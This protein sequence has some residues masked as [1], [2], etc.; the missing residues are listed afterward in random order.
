MLR[1][2]PDE[3]G[4]DIDAYG[5]VPLQQ[6]VDAVR[7]RYEEAGEAD[8]LELLDSPDQHR[9]E[10]VEGKIRALYGHSFFVEMDGEPLV[11]PEVLYM[12]TTATDARRFGR[13][14]IVPNDR[15]Y[16]HLSQSREV[17]AERSREPDGPVVIEVM[18]RAAAEAG[19][20]FYARGEV[21]LTRQIP[22]EFVGPVHG[23]RTGASR[24]VVAAGPPRRRAPAPEATTAAAPTE[25]PPTSRPEGPINYGRKLRKAT[26]R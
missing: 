18:A 24:R 19:I 5:F 26:R 23:V 8:V 21:V 12:G 25:E 1:H 11:A 22:V 17:A 10:I 2:R 15:F 16:V 4:L 13:D 14:G 3:F 20:V 9:F 6:V 7:E